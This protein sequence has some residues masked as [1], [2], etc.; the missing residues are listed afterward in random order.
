MESLNNKEWDGF[1]DTSSIKTNY[2]QAH[3]ISVLPEEILFIKSNGDYATL[4]T[5]QQ[6]ENKIDLPINLKKAE[7]LLGNQGFCRVHKRYLINLAHVRNDGELY[8]YQVDDV[9][10][11]RY[12]RLGNGY[13]ADVSRRRRKWFK[14]CMQNI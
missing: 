7:K 13:R 11:R 2:L 9:S 6:T 10:D 1:L 5:S 14:E 3:G 4:Y 8:K 12:V